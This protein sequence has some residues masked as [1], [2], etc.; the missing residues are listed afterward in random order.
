MKANELHDLMLRL[1][2][3]TILI[4]GDLILD[5]YLFGQVDRL[6]P[7]AP[8]P[9]LD[10]QRDEY[11]LGGAANVAHNIATMGGKAIV[12]GAMGA[13]QPKDMFLELLQKA[14]I[15]VSGVVTD[16]SRPTIVKTRV[17]G[18]NQQL[19]R[20]DREKRH[21]L[22]GVAF[23]KM[24]A[25]LQKAINDVSAIVI[26][27]YGK[28]VIT[29][30]TLELIRELTKDKDIP[31]V[32][33]PKDTHFSN[34][35]QFTVITPNI[36]EASLGAGFKIKDEETLLQAGNH[37]VTSL[38]CSAIL[39]TRGAEGMS[40]FRKEKDVLAIPTRARDVFDVTGAGDTVVA[41]LAL[42]LASGLSM[43]ESAHLANW[44]AGVVVAKHGT[45]TSTREE[46]DAYVKRFAS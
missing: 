19:V 40:L 46:L 25:F 21:N 38:D 37:L 10:Y 29:T 34:Y 16:E 17:I 45:A 33:D 20:V 30:D 9:V 14:G 35:R 39:I 8:V 7:E 27:D 12:S 1:D 43:V 18:G 5:R 24:R 4:V 22:E 11:V 3:P 15:C 41:M 26:S 13:D 42:S 6:S 23:E 36:N 31:V 44:T 2:E 28:G 32:V